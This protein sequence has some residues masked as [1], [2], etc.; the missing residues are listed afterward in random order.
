MKAAI[1]LPD[2]LFLR[3]DKFAQDKGLSRS[4]FVAEALR[5]YIDRHQS[6]DLTQ[7]I[8][9]AIA[10]EGQPVDEVVLRQSRRRLRGVEW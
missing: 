6:A 4:A 2:D 5:E 8:N 9:D 7:R 1:S 3:A 10:A